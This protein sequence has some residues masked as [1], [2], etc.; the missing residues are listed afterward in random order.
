MRNRLDTG[1]D[2]SE[3]TTVTLFVKLVT[4]MDHL[5]IVNADLKG[6]IV[7]ELARETR[8][9]GKAE[10][11]VFNEELISGSKVDYLSYCMDKSDPKN[12]N[13]LHGLQKTLSWMDTNKVKLKGKIAYLHRFEI[14][15]SYRGMGLARPYIWLLLQE[16]KKELE[17]E[18]VILIA[19]PFKVEG[20]NQE[21]FQRQKRILEKLYVKSGFSILN[22][23]GEKL[24][25]KTG[26][27][28][29][30]LFC[31]IKHKTFSKFST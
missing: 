30:H 29:E 1:R 3:D 7:S 6:D 10:L 28:I 27:E 13:A 15:T 24:Y 11:V 22:K 12:F 20:S 9:M 31:D 21:E 8:N 16:L 23:K 5:A 26:V 14:F 25:S 17:I 19:Y 4:T 2:N 18:G